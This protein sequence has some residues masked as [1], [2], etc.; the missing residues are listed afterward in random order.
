VPEIHVR[1]RIWL[2]DEGQAVFGTGICDLLRGVEA[3]GSLHRAAADLGIAYSK[4]WTIVRRAEEH[5]A[6]KLLSERRAGGP[7][8]G[9]STVSAEGQWLVEQFSALVAEANDYLE[10]QFAFRL[11]ARLRAAN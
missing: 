2:D 3:T 5:L 9:G 6:M 10:Q 1:Q 11:L 7:E 4:A 8:G